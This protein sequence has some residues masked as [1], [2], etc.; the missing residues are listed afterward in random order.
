MRWFRKTA[1]VTGPIVDL[2]NMVYHPA[3]KDS[4]QIVEESRTSTKSE[5][6]PTDKPLNKKD[7]A[8]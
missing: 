8:N 1:R 4:S 7:P 3:A 5:P 6:S 2:T